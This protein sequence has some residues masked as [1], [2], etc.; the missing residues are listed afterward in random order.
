V[1]WRWSAIELD[2]D[3]CHHLAMDRHEIL[4][5]LRDHERELKADGIVHL[6]VFGSVAR[7]EASAHSDVD[8]VADFDSSKR[9]TLVTLGRLQ[10]RL[11]ELL[12][13]EVDLSSPAWMKD[14][15]RTK[16]M[17]EAVRAF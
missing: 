17:H 10:S 12:G 14:P 15:V 4:Q 16:A 11:S 6:G 5:I 1:C 7:G 9:L 2:I 13:V 8:L 3:V